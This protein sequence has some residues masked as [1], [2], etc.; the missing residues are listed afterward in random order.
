[1]AKG[2]LEWEHT[3]GQ[4]L[5]L[6]IRPPFGEIFSDEARKHARAARKEMLLTVRSLIDIAVKRMEEKENKTKTQ[7]TKIPVE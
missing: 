3:P 1:M 4:E 5:I 2:S 6:K 7:G